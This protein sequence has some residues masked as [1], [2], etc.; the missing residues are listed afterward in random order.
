MSLVPNDPLQEYDVREVIA[1]VVDGSRFTEYREEFG[2]TIT[3]GYARIDGWSVGIV[4]NQ[5]MHV[6]DPGKPW[7]MGGRDLRGLREQGR[8]VHPRLQPK[9]HPPRVPARRERLHGGTNERVRRHHPRG[10]EDGERG[11]EQRR[12]EDHD[13]PWRQLRRGTLRDVRQGV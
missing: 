13:D 10:R 2:K 12:P 7:Q 3:C 6:R 4:A 8:A 9:T 5:K 1:R 11:V